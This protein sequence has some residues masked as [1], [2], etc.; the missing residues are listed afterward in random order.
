[1]TLAPMLLLATSLV[2]QSA[3]T[4]LK[5]F[6]S[7]EG[8]FSATLP[9]KP[10]VSSQDI[11]TPIGKIAMRTYM[12][13]TG[14]NATAVLYCDYPESIAKADPNKVLDGA[15]NGAITSIKGKLVE[16]KSVKMGE[17]PGRAFEYEMRRN[18]VSMVG[19][20]RLYLDKSRLYQ[21]M[22]IGTPDFARS[23]TSTKVLDSFKITK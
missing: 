10:V 22:V 21:V 7:A 13:E 5:P 14:K 4:D 12:I 8:K 6:D 15:R 3:S 18:G 9:G 16:G 23:E 20:C 1:M 2:A 17:I 11:P 19:R